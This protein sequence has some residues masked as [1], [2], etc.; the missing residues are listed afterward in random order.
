MKYNIE[1]DSETKF[2]IRFA[3]NQRLERIEEHLVKSKELNLPDTV[4]YWEE[5]KNVTT[6]TINEIDKNTK[7]IW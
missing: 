6:K 4:K 3:L 5:E 7:T 1:V 2:M